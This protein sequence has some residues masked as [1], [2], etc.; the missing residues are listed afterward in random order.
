MHSRR[1]A[2]SEELDTAKGG[3]SAQIAEGAHATAACLCSRTGNIASAW[4]TALLG[5]AMGMSHVDFA[6]CAQSRI[7]E[8]SLPCLSNDGDYLWQRSGTSSIHSSRIPGPQVAAGHHRRPP[9][10]AH[11]DVA[12][13]HCFGGAIA[14]EQAPL[15]LRLRPHGSP[16]SSFTATRHDV[17]RCPGLDRFRLMARR[18][19]PP[20]PL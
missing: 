19:R 18:L 4:L 13:S 9:Q 20:S 2:D 16:D 1:A 12:P 14:L 10:H 17:C 8:I 3:C 11:G 7:S 15:G 5:P 6:V